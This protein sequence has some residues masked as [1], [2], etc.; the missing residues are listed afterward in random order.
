LV[1]V[2][3]CFVVVGVTFEY[4]GRPTM[5]TAIGEQR[6]LSLD[7][8]SRVE[9]NTDTRLLVKFDRRTRT[10]V[11]KSGEAYF[12][13][14][15]ES[16]PFVVVAGDRK[17]IAVG[18]EFTVRKDQSSSDAVTVTLI[19]GRVAV[20]PL[21]AANVLA[22]VPTASVT[23][24][25]AGQ[26]LQVHGHA[27]PRVDAPPIDRVTGWLR[28][29]LIFDHTPLR[30]AAAEFSRYSH[31]RITV[32]SPDVANIPIGGIFKIGDINSFLDAVAQ[33]HNLRIVVSKD[34]LVLQRLPDQAQPQVAGRMR[35]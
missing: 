4:A 30:D 2:V 13:V 31:I 26:R 19:E 22:P 10:V 27:M 20:A 14:M 32:A 25:N 8:G 5:M 34:G 23:V 11:L 29:E 6:S 24:L 1:F 12:Q 16:R 33:S 18:T 21:N 28:G 9:L 17:V 7:D 3:V 15:H 35:L